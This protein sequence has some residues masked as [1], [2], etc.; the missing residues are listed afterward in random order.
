MARPIGHR[1]CVELCTPDWSGQGRLAGVKTV[2][3]VTGSGLAHSIQASQPRT[4][5]KAHPLPG[6][7]AGSRS[8]LAHQ[9]GPMPVQVH[10]TTT[11]GSHGEIQVAEMLTAIGWAPPGKVSQ[12]I[13][14]DL[15]TMARHTVVVEDNTSTWD[16]AAPVFLQVKSSP[17]AYA[18]PTGKRAGQPGWWFSE[19]SKYKFDHWLEFGLPYLVVLVDIK[20]RVAY[21]AEVEAKAIDTTKK[22]RRIFVPQSQTIDAD[23]L[24]ALNAVAVKRRASGLAGL[25][26]NGMLDQLPVADRLRYALTMPRVIAPHVNRSFSTLTYVEAI[27]LILRGR[28]TDLQYGSQDGDRFP[29]V[30]GWAD[31][32]EWG[33]RLAYGLRAVV[34]DG[35]DFD[36]SEL[37]SRAPEPFEA[38][39]CRVVQAF[40]HHAWG[41]TQEALDVLVPHP[42]TLP[43]DL[44]WILNHKAAMLLEL[45]RP[46]EAAEVAKSALV[47][48]AALEGDL[49]I[50]AIRGAAAST[51]YAAADVGASD[52]GEVLTAADNASAWWRSVDIA[53]GLSRDLNSRF[54]GWS[55]AARTRSMRSTPIG[56]LHAAAM[57]AGL[58]GSWGAW[59]H[60]N[61]Q[62]AKMLLTSSADE[63]T[64][65]WALE[66]LVEVGDTAAV[67]N[68]SRK[69][70]NDGPVEVLK[71][72]SAEL[73][74]ASWPKRS[75]GAIIGLLGCGG[76]LLDATAAD[77]VIKRVFRAI[78]DDGP[79]RR[80]AGGFTDRWSELPDILTQVLKAASPQGHEEC[81]A[82]IVGFLPDAPEGIA[83]A[84][85]RV[86]A[87][88]NIEHLS[89]ELQ[90]QLIAA[91]LQRTGSLRIWLL[92]PLAAHNPAA[93]AA[94]R[95]LADN[96]SE[97]ATR[98]LLAA[99]GDDPRDYE[100]LGASSATDVQ[101]RVNRARETPGISFGSARPDQ[102]LTLCMCAFHSR[103]PSLWQTVIDALSAGVL[104]GPTITESIHWLAQH[105]S[106]LP[107]ETQHQLRHLAPALTVDG[108]PNVTDDIQGCRTVLVVAT[109]G[110]D[111]EQAY[112]HLLTLALTSPTTAARVARVWKGP[113]KLTFL[114]G[115]CVHDQWQ[116]RAWAV[117]GLVEHAALVSG[118]AA[119]VANV[120]TAALAH[121]PSCQVMEYA[122]AAMSDSTAPELQELRI[123]LSSHPSATVRTALSPP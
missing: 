107:V 100:S 95:E 33:W 16:L 11:T 55:D 49:S 114:A 103:N 110:F 78:D 32:P 89:D 81:A 23:H 75:E 59:R 1:S 66:T 72:V 45:D 20:R 86:N 52:L 6:S 101:Q 41:R 28:G 121:E 42:S 80:F 113:E 105:F 90:T 29:A 2:A 24:A 53:D 115:L 36:F 68:A 104:A 51:L 91:A 70:W 13:G 120:L 38:N 50:S 119:A 30:S 19:E 58:A 26:W 3:T 98:S 79:T 47:T 94:L 10:H 74:A 111:A 44:G 15:F 77:N 12:D 57:V 93:V 7:S 22:R 99:G 5:T 97:E 82:R 63:P 116:V 43:A 73:A 87:A 61:G 117:Y 118:D 64:V 56:D 67:K 31:H 69:V 4:H 18:A 60:I 88:L 83:H 102:L 122:A 35:T 46:Y 85:V 108:D 40:V 21:W 76:D 14:D 96:G 37:I 112:A 17:K 27:A 123:R 34:S 62:I 54:E 9:N 39:A 109:G 8:G 92:E 106:E 84:L 65:K 71:R 25:A 48:V